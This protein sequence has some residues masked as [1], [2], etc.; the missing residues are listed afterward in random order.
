M[1]R[2]LPSIVGLFNDLLEKDDGEN[3]AFEAMTLEYAN[4]YNLTQ[5]EVVDAIA[6]IAA[7]RAAAQVRESEAT[8]NNAQA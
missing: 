4:K 2:E 5:D 7:D 6:S 8:R 1:S 3:G